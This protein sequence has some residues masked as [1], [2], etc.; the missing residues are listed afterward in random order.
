MATTVSILGTLLPLSI[1][2]HVLRLM[3]TRSAACACVNLYE[4]RS[5]HNRIPNCW[6]LNRSWGVSCV[7]GTINGDS[8]ACLSLQNM[9]L[10]CSTVMLKSSIFSMSHVLHIVSACSCVHRCITARKI[11][12]GEANSNLHVHRNFDTAIFMRSALLFLYS[13]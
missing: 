5:L 1:E 10:N 6:L 4:S 2:F 7:C 11:Q 8:L 9:A 3:P 12:Y 13:V